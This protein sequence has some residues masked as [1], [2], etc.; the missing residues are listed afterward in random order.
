MRRCDAGLHARAKLSAVTVIVAPPYVLPAEGR[1]DK[2]I[3]AEPEADGA[4]PRYR[5]RARQALFV[6]A[7]AAT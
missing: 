4:P 6:I 3:I 2:A 5:L 7:D 1:D